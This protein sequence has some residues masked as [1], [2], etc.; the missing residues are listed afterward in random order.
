MLYALKIKADE[1]I[2]DASSSLLAKRDAGGVLRDKDIGFPVKELRPAS[3]WNY[4]LVADGNGKPHF[5]VKGMGWN[6]VLW[7]RL[8]V[9]NMRDG[10]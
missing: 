3:I 1:K 4:A 10:G 9:R 6:A 2:V 7:S 5:D 8:C